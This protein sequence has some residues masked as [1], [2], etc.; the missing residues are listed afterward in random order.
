MLQGL[1]WLLGL[2]GM[3]GSVVLVGGTGSGLLCHLGQ[4]AHLTAK[5]IAQG[6]ASYLGSLLASVLAGAVLKDGLCCVLHHRC[7]LVLIPWVP[8]QHYAVRLWE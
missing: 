5:A 8:L 1:G 7:S 6:R 4:A 2:G 3:M